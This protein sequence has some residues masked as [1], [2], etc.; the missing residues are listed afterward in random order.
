MSSNFTMQKTCE[1]CGKLFVARTSV[2]R[3]CS[4]KCNNKN[5]K[6]RKKAG[7][8][9]PQQ[10]VSKKRAVHTLEELTSLEFL[11]VKGAARLLGASEKIVR[12]M[13][14][15]GRLRATNLSVRKTI[16][17]RKDI[18]A[19]FD[20]PDGSSGKSINPNYCKMAD[21]AVLF[22]ISDSALFEVIRRNN[23]PKFKEGKYTYV[24]KSDLEKVLTLK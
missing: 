12:T 6:L 3:F 19:L 17:S 10:K 16:I 11:D 15:S 20:R 13:I 24:A 18:D 22:G 1:Q 2:T 21:A 23:I 8:I 4:S 9:F 5:I 14:S 7:Y